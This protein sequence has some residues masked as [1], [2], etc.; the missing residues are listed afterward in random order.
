M[1]AFPYPRCTSVY[2]ESHSGIC[3]EG[4]DRAD[5]DLG[6]AGDSLADREVHG[7]VAEPGKF[8]FMAGATTAYQ[9]SL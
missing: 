6:K 2:E 5:C 8:D 9:S 7:F 1:G 4:K 3:P